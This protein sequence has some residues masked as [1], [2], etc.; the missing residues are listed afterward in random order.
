MNIISKGVFGV[1][2]IKKYV[3]V[4]FIIISIILGILLCVCLFPQ[5]VML[6][7]NSGG[8]NPPQPQIT[9]G[10]FPFKLEYEINGEII[11]IEDV[12][13]CEYDGV[14]IGNNGKFLKWKK[15]IASTGEEDLLLL[16]E[17]NKK[18]FC[19]VGNA[20]YYMG[21]IQEDETPNPKLYID[22]C[23]ETITTSS[24]DP[25]ELEKYN[26]RI[27]HYEFSQPIENIFK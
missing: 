23:K 2:D 15:R 25:V 16:S 8:K 18:I 6:L 26:I 20:N 5:V 3:L 4:I 27:I 9:Y 19:T 17:E 7:I 10:E 1:C 12:L 14:G 21:E 13:I 11:K 22:E 24:S